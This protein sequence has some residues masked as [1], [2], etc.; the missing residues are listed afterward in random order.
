[1]CRYSTTAHYGTMIA[2]ELLTLSTPL[3]ITVPDLSKKKN[4]GS[5]LH[6]G[7]PLFW[8]D[9]VRNAADTAGS[10]APTSTIDQQQPRLL[11]PNSNMADTEVPVAQRGMF[12]L[13]RDILTRKHWLSPY[14]VAC[15]FLADC[16][17]CAL[18]LW[19]VPCKPS[20]ATPPA[21]PGRSCRR[22]RS[23]KEES[24]LLT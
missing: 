1:M 14:L 19:K 4:Y 7:D 9:Y 11:P 2:P 6:S 8:P 20:L 17:V 5:P 18:I 12:A 13:G 16:L 23:R 21:E 24:G 3:P 10:Q 15:F 22:R